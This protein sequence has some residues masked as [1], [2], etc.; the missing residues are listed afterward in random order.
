M[1]DGDTTLVVCDTCGYDWDYGG[2]LRRATCPACGHKTPV[3]DG[4]TDSDEE[5]YIPGRVQL[6][7]DALTLLLRYTYVDAA[8]THR[9]ITVTEHD[10]RGTERYEETR[11]TESDVWRGVGAEPVSEVDVEVPDAV[12]DDQSPGNRPDAEDEA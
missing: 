3:D 7:D 6:N 2:E 10:D 8:G 1:R 11:E 9:R 12:T 5:H 4:D